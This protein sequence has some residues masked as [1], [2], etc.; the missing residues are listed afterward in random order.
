MASEINTCE[1]DILLAIRKHSTADN[2]AQNIVQLLGYDLIPEPQWLMLS[3]LPACCTLC[4]SPPIPLQ[5]A[6]FV[7]LEVHA[8]LKFLHRECDP[9]IAHGDLHSGNV[10]VG[11]AD[12]GRLKILLINFGEAE[13][14][15]DI[16]VSL[17]WDIWHLIVLVVD[18][19]KKRG[20]IGQCEKLE[21]LMRVESRAEDEWC[22]LDRLWKEFGEVA[23][24]SVGN[25]EAMGRA[26][27]L[28][29]QVVQKQ[30]E[31]LGVQANYF[32]VGSVL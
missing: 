27:E 11:F 29:D 18:L 13:A 19:Y 1:R 15:N 24:K 31:Y 2:G 25:A 23:G 8:A 21:E 32:R 16:D 28:V 26:K 30:G 22:G 12:N 6:C 9:P 3:T 7:F 4:D 5:Y 14:G 10:L 20:Y 17:R